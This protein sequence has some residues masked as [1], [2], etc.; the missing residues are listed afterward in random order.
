MKGPILQLIS[1]EDMTT[2]ILS[3]FSVF[4]LLFLC[5]PFRAYMKAWVAKKLG[6]DT[7]ESAGMLTLNPLVHIDLMGAL[8]MLLCCFG[9]SRPTPI[10]LSR[11]RKYSIRKSAI[12]ISLM[13]IMSLII[14][15]LILI[16]IS[17]VLFLVF[18]TTE[19]IETVSMISGAL[20]QAA[21]ISVY[22]A[23][24]NLIPVPGFDG[25]V[26]IQGILPRNAAIFIERNSNIINLIVL[27]LLVSGIL[28]GP[29]SFL[30]AIIYLG[31]DL[32][33]FWIG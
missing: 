8:C 26:L 7:A 3:F 13:G 12:L 20:S 24:L 15:G 18:K 27:V 33:T 5:F 25:Y 1:G 21:L 22:I 32:I 10:N 11:C 19:V 23:V 9:W 29:L 30:S 31:L 17:K 28:S 16:I 2:V 4:V 14:L 6:D